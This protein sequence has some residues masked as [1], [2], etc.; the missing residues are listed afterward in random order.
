MNP[1]S[2]P[3]YSMGNS[4]SP[5]NKNGFS[6]LEVLIACGVLVVGLASIA[7]ILPAATA[8][9]REAATIDRAGATAAG[10][11][12]DFDCRDLAFRELFLVASGSY[13][14]ARQAVVFGQGLPGVPGVVVTSGSPTVL[15]LSSSGSALLARRIDMSAD[16]VNRSFFSEDELQFNPATGLSPL[17][18]FTNGVREFRRG[19]CWGAMVEPYPWH[20][21]PSGSA[22]LPAVPMR[23][24][25][26]TIAVFRKPGAVQRM[27]LSGSAGG[28]F[29]IS[30]LPDDSARKRFLSP[31]APILA[32][33]QSGSATPQWLTVNSSWPQ[34]APGFD[35]RTTPPTSYGVVFRELGSVYQPLMT[36][37]TLQ[38][39]GFE[40]I[41]SIAQ[42]IFTIK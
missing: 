36:G 10:A 27:V 18:V 42:Q 24:V 16:D 7:S 12:A 28:L 19:V 33:A 21:I 5:G 34:W 29:S 37:S 17:N 14:P 26:A 22:T 25:R 31:C 8:R 2:R 23:A 11:L 35:P 1:A 3:V 4:F 38:V 20:A 30:T 9:L 41:Q 6:L 40:N 13:M 32:V 39:I 15:T